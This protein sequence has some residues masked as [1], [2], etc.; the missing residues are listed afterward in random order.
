M[1]FNVAQLLKASPGEER[2]YTVREE[3]RRYEELAR[4]V[5]GDVR[6]MRTDRG[7]L[8]MADVETG[9]SCSC[10]RCLEGFVLPVA[11]KVVEEYFPTVDIVTGASVRTPEGGFAID[12]HHILDLGE[13][14]H[15]HALLA[16]PMKP[17]CKP[18]CAGLCPSCGADLNE[19]KCECPPVVTDIRWAKLEG[20]KLRLGR[21]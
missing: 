16:Y 9:V 14:V 19:G 21:N 12:T 3:E 15:Q 11:L 17:L 10:S 20:L 8:V 2:R 13:A 6:L 5:E 7:V 1:Q 18:D 4:D